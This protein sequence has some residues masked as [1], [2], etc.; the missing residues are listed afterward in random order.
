MLGRV[1]P[2]SVAYAV[3]YLQSDRDRDDV[4]LQVASDDQCRVY[5]NGRAVHENALPSLVT[6]L[7]QTERVTLRK[8]TNVLVFKVVNELVLWQGCVRLVD[9]DGKPVEG[10]HVRL[11]P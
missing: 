6:D 11:T 1:T 2:N 5:L 3:C 4:R 8:G 7:K 10:V 9:T